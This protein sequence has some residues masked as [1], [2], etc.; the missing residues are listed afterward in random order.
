MRRLSLLFVLC[1]MLLAACGGDD[2]PTRQEFATEANKVC[3]DLE[4]T[5][6][7]LKEPESVAEIEQYATDLEKEV[8]EAVGKLDDLERPSGE[9]GE[10]A[11][12]FID[13]IKKGT[14]DQIKPALAELREAAQA[15]DEKAIVAAAEKIEKVETPEADRLANELGAKECAN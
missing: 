13:E 9:D 10:K 8:D 12:K 7:T 1:S 4:R 14:D 5:G 2:G 11:D 15:K 6:D 3:K